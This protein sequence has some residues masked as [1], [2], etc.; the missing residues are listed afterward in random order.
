M[1]SCHHVAVVVVDIFLLN[2]DPKFRLESQ[3]DGSQNIAHY[4]Q[5]RAQ[6][7]SAQPVDFV[8]R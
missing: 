6:E 8:G 4:G 5:A 7:L 1:P 3:N 2:N